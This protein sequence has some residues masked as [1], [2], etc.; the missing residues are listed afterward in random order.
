MSAE[1][2]AAARRAGVAAS[3]V[4][5]CGYLAAAFVRGYGGPMVNLAWLIAHIVLAPGIAIRLMGEPVP[6][7]LVVSDVPFTPTFVAEA[8]LMG[9]A[10]LVTY[11]GGDTL[12]F[13]LACTPAERVEWADEY[14]PSLFR[15]P[16]LDPARFDR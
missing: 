1:G 16:L 6:D 4:I 5:L 2:G 10:P 14:L 9:V 3:G 13:R 11:I 15:D 12:W 8:L 7:S